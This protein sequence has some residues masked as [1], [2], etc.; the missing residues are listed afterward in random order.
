[1]V[2]PRQEEQTAD[3]REFSRRVREASSRFEQRRATEKQSA[4]ADPAPTGGRAAGEAE[5][6]LL[7]AMEELNVADEELRQQN[8]ELIRA[9][10]DLQRERQTYFELF[11]FAPDA[12]LVTDAQGVIR[13]ANVAASHLLGVPAQFLIGKPLPTYF[14]QNAKRSYRQQLDRLCGIERIDDWEIALLPRNGQPMAASISIGRISK[15]GSGTVG[16]RWILRDITKR[17]QAEE[18]VRELNRELELRVVS[19][20]TQLAAANQIKDE[21][22][23]SERK[24]RE[25][26]ETSNRVKSD[27]LA[28]LSHEFRTPLQ[29]IFGYTELLE[30]EIHGPLNELQRRDLQRIQQSQQHLLGL[31]NTIL[32]FAKLESGKP[33]EV[34][35]G[36]VSMSESLEA[37]EAMIE[38]SLE[39]KALSYDYRC[40]DPAVVA[41]GDAAKIQQ[42]VLNL[43]ANA[44]KFTP[45]GGRISL[46][47]SAADDLVEVR[48]SD[49]GPG[50]PVDKLETI[51]EPFV[52][53]KTK[54]TV[55]NGTGLG[56]PISRRLASAMGGSLI[57]ESNESGSTFFLRLQRY[58]PHNPSS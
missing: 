52:Q 37:M 46:E 41:Y 1:M 27:F 42:I 49:S 53:L 44:V 14:E 25:A 8:E 19:R 5:V 10:D 9:R 20:T 15:Q 29:A 17:K 54:G 23:L 28:L 58:R 33:I 36:P 18:S 38:P 11:D 22:L 56:L 3:I 43:L 57:A 13:E 32:E 51:F 30:R 21:L 40:T 2:D 39:T 55:A 47:C 31:I 26:A 35:L 34:S 50:I 45:V 24:A 16:Y 12:Y 6:E 7:S 48:V 4:P